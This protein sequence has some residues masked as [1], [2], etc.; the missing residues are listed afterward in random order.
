VKSALLSLV[1]GFHTLRI[2]DQKTWR[3]LTP[4]FWRTSF[5]KR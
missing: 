2:E 5:T 4:P 3:L 1:I